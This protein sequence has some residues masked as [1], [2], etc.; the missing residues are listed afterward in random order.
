MIGQT[1]TCLMQPRSVS[2]TGHQAERQS[3][4]CSGGGGGVGGWV[5]GR[6]GT[7]NEYHAPRLCEGERV[8]AK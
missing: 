4:T 1:L 3:G 5:G 6:G 2:Q 8:V 7:I